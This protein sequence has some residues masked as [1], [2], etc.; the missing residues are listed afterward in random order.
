[1]S[2]CAAIARY[3][4]ELE[5]HQD[6]QELIL[7]R[8]FYKMWVNFHQLAK[9]KQTEEN[10]VRACQTLLDMKKAIEGYY[11]THPKVANG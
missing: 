3:M 9:D 2:E 11:S 7:L 1:M 10:A 4:K 5:T 6:S 8:D